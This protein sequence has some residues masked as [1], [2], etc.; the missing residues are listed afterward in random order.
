MMPPLQINSKG[1]E[2][3]D[4]LHNKHVFIFLKITNSS[5]TGTNILTTVLVLKIR[6]ASHHYRV[7]LYRNSPYM[8]RLVYPFIE[9]SFLGLR[10]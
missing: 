3:E 6:I 4:G 1:K 7:T 5:V 2:F 10:R 9:P 8:T